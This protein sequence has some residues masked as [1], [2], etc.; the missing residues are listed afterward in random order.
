MDWF[1]M[2]SFKLCLVTGFFIIIPSPV[3]VGIFWLVVS[4]VTYLPVLYLP[5]YC[6]HSSSVQLVT[7]DGE[8]I[9][10]G[11]QHINSRK[12]K[13]AW[14]LTIILPLYTVNYI[15]ACAGGITP[16]ETIVIYQ[17]L[18]VATKGFFASVT[19]VRSSLLV[20][21]LSYHRQ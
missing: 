17:V 7:A 1:L 9:E 10:L 16:A 21:I 4:C 19:I 5:C 2:I 18:S 12:Q 13:L 8:M 11:M 15:I 20:N 14:V 3:A 6:H